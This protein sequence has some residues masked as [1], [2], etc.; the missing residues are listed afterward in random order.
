[1][2]VSITTAIQSGCGTNNG[3]A[4]Y[5]RSK[6]YHGYHGNYYHGN[7]DKYVL[8]RVKNL[9]GSLKIHHSVADTLTCGKTFTMVTM[10]IIT[11]VAMVVV[12]I[13]AMATL[14]HHRSSSAVE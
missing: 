11:M 2:L 3:R 7:H 13:M 12:T 5:F 10:V 14:R 8:P 1:M 9:V 6:Y 4:L